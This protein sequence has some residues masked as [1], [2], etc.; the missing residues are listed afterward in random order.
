MSPGKDET[1]ACRYI[2]WQ[3]S[4][5]GALSTLMT[6]VVLYSLTRATLMSPEKDERRVCGFICREEREEGVYMQNEHG[7][8]GGDKKLEVSSER[9]F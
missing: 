7:W 4:A 2:T 1:G 9:T 8:K 5:P 3:S 6:S